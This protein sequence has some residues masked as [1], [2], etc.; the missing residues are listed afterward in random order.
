MYAYSWITRAKK[1]KLNFCGEASWFNTCCRNPKIS[2]SWRHLW[3]MVEK[4]ENCKCKGIVRLLDYFPNANRIQGVYPSDR[5]NQSKFEFRH[6]SRW[7]KKLYSRYWE[8]I[9]IHSLLSSQNNSMHAYKSQVKINR[10]SI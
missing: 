9:S 7:S 4:E 10:V 6:A 1:A 2:K 5:L 8:F 3:Y